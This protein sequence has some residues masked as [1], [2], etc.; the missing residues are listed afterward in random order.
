MAKDDAGDY[1]KE[2]P[3]VLHPLSIQ[4][5]VLLTLFQLDFKL[6]QVKTGI[7]PFPG[8]DFRV[9]GKVLFPIP[10]HFPIPNSPERG[11]IGRKIQSFKEIGLPLAVLTNQ[12]DILFPDIPL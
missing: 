4:K 5:R 7:F 12:K 6:V 9:N 2:V 3:A 8:T 1:G 11:T 10:G